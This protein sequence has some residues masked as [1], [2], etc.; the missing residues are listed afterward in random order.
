MRRGRPTANDS[1]GCINDPLKRHLPRYYSAGLPHTDTVSRYALYGAQITG[2]Q[3]SLGDAVPS[4]ASSKSGVQR[5][6]HSRSR[7]ECRFPGSGSRPPWMISGGMSV[8]FFPLSITSLA[9]DESRSR[10]FSCCQMLHLVTK[11]GLIPLRDQPPPPD[12]STNRVSVT[13]FT[14]QDTILS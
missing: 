10:L 5:C 3:Q 4:R 14:A 13:S 7:P 6:L 12:F 9:L 11:G 8:C 2:H 1:L